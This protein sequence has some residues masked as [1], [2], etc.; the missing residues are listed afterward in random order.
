M[1]AMTPFDA[2]IRDLG[3]ALARRDRETIN[4]ILADLLARN[5]PLG[6]P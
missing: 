3:Q 1:A 5:A 4:T 6:D 2:A